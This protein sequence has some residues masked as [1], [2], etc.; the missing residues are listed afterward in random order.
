MSENTFIGYLF[1]CSHGCQPEVIPPKKE[2]KG[3]SKKIVC[4]F[5]GNR[6]TY[7]IYRCV[8]CGKFFKKPSTVRKTHRCDLCQTKNIKAVSREH[9]KKR[10]VLDKK[11]KV[12]FD[13][14]RRG[15]CKWGTYCIDQQLK[16]GIEFNC[17]ECLKFEPLT[18]NVLD[19]MGTG[20]DILARGCEM[21]GV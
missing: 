2:R 7:R 15:A 4:P 5:C 6:E 14:T 9:Y 3:K 17:H 1:G 18:L 20:V 10:Q 19:Y 12:T 13:Q 11:R 16:T 8:E 21:S